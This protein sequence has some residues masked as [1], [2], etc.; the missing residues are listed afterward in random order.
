ML[1]KKMPLLLK[2]GACT[3]IMWCILQ[4][5]ESC[6]VFKHYYNESKS[7]LTPTQVHATRYS[8][9]VSRPRGK[10]LRVAEHSNKRS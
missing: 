2:T 5:T 4:H 6:P 7:A 1:L 10:W 9:A 8:D 3:E